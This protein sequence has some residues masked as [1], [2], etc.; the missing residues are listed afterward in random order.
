MWKYVAVI[1]GVLIVVIVG[2]FFGY[3]YMQRSSPG[4]YAKHQ[5]MGMA[6]LKE[7]VLD[8]AI[9]ELEIA[10][11][12]KPDSMEASYGLG[13]AYL[14][15][16]KPE[17]AAKHFEETL[18]LAPG[19]LDIVYSLGVT[20]QQMGRL[21]KAL[22]MYHQVAKENPKSYQVFN[23]VGIIQ[24]KLG[25]HEKAV[26]AYKYAIELSP[27]YYPAR[28]N[29]ARE[30]EAQKMF[31]LAVKEYQLVVVKASKDPKTANIAKF[32]EERLSAMKTAGGKTK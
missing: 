1:V 28:I 27:D 31:D 3:R 9:K 19:R 15:L 21:E 24:G 16:K 13:I 4:Y 22:E 14:R 7:G 20:Y 17:E 30:Y 23:N 10:K 26:K 11:D 8:M 25:D 5:K 32:A 12:V 29:L 6:F 18:R 2:G